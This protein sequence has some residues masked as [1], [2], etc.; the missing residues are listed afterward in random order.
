MNKTKVQDL[1]DHAAISASVLCM[2]HCLATPFLLIM[3]PILSSTFLADEAFHRTLVLFVLPTSLIALFIGC[4]RHKDRNVMYVGFV[5]LF[6]LVFIA[7]FGHDLFGETGEKAATVVC[8]AILAYAHLRNY[9][10]CRR[11]SCDA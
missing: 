2:V 4:G 5:G 11:A 7:Y 1:L 10:L 9:R 3:V 8:G 6:S